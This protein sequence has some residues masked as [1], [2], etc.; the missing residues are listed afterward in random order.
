[1]VWFVALLP[2]REVIALLDEFGDDA[3]TA[4]ALPARLVEV[5]ADLRAAVLGSV[6]DR[7]LLGWSYGVHPLLGKDGEARRG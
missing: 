4:G 3:G 5:V 1:V 6:P 2:E 7:P